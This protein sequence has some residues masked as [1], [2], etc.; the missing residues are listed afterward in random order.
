MPTVE[1]ISRILTNM[2]RDRYKA[3]VSYIYYLAEIPASAVTSECEEH[4]QRSRQ[5]EF[6]KKTAGKI[7]VDEDA[8]TELRMGSMI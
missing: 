5:I 8:I 7:S 2:D 1:D 3:A 4:T 6:V